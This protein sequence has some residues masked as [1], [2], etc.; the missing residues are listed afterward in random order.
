[1]HDPY[2]F[3]T[4]IFP[5]RFLSHF[6]I[7]LPCL[8]PQT[9]YPVSFVTSYLLY[10]FQDHNIQTYPARGSGVLLGVGSSQ[11]EQTGIEADHN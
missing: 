3:L 9:L 7:V 8:V 5:D 1:M 10:I 6:F 2:S 11:G 4:T